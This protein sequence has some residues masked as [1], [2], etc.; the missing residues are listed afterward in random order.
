MGTALS[1]RRHSCCSALIRAVLVSVLCALALSG[2]SL[3]RMIDS[4]VQ[5]FAG[6]S[7]PVSGADFR[8]ERLPSQQQNAGQQEALE[9]MTQEALERVGLLR[10]DA[11]GR[12]LVLVGFSVDNIRNPYY[13]PQ[14]P[15]FVM[16]NNGM[17]MEVWPRVTDMEVPWF[18]HRLQLTLRDSSNGQLAFETSAV[19]DGPWSDTPNLLPPMLEAALQDYPQTSRRTIRVEL[20]ARSAGLR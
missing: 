3:P 19:F 6:S 10:K 1:L 12:Y 9:A 20:P 14:S 11:G 4:E 7:A 16:G 15:R 2:C 17:L 13:R 5:S 18:R 8:F